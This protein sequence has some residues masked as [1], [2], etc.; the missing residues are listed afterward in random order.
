M[1]KLSTPIFFAFWSH[2]LFTIG[3][4]PAQSFSQKRDILFTN[5]ATFFLCLVSTTIFLIDLSLGHFERS[6]VNLSVLVLLM[7]G[8]LLQFRKQYD[9]AKVWVIFVPTIMAIVSSVIF[10]FSAK[11][12]FYT[13]ACFVLGLIMFQDLSQH[14]ILFVLFV[15][16]MFRLLFVEDSWIPFIAGQD[17]SWMKLIHLPLVIISVFVTLRE[18]ATVFQS[19]ETKVADLVGSIQEKNAELQAQTDFIQDQTLALQSTNLELQKSVREHEKTEKLLRASNEN[20]EHFAYMA[21][22][23]LKEPLRTVVVLL[24]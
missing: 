3:I 8:Y 6:L 11:A 5:E 21:S 22:H 19:F 15:P 18:Y 14:A 16:L 17:P 24:L 4:H 23:D 20:L 12:H 10:G 9:L 1:L 2:K 13:F 7:P